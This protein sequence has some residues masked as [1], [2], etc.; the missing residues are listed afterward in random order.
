MENRYP[1]EVRKMLEEALQQART[2][3]GDPMVL[4]RITEEAERIRNRVLSQHGKLNIGVPTIR[5]LRNGH[6]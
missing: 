2:G 4:Q 6:E 1:R 5:A 3:C